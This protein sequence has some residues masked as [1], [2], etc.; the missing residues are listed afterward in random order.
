MRR[1]LRTGCRIP[2]DQRDAYQ[3]T[4]G[5]FEWEAA[6]SG[7]ARQRG[8]ELVE[9]LLD[10]HTNELRKRRWRLVEGERLVT[11][12]GEV[13]IGTVCRQGRAFTVL[14]VVDDFRSWR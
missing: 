14:G 3:S 11:Q 2:R 6:Q 12:S 10:T 7:A 8:Y 4:F 13:A 9:R 5:F 1:I